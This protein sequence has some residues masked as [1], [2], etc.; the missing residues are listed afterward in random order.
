MQEKCRI[1]DKYFS[2]G[3]ILAH[4]I[5]H[6]LPELIDYSEIQNGGDIDGKRTYICNQCG[7]KPPCQTTTGILTYLLDTV[8]KKVPSEKMIS[9]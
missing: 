1:C 9:N 7:Y 2:I 6:F 8:C 3:T 4:E 5:D